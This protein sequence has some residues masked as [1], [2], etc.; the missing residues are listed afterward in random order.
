MPLR[1]WLLIL[2]PLV[3]VILLLDRP[4]STKSVHH[5]EWLDAG[6]AKLRGIR[7]GAG[8]TTLLLLHGFGESLL[9]WRSLVDPLAK[10]FRVVAV[11]VPPFGVSDKPSG[12]YS[13][14]SMTDRLN[15]LVDRWIPGP[16][17]VIGHSM[18]GELAVA[19]ALS[20]PTRVNALVLIAPA[21]IAIGMGG[22]LDTVRAGKAS[23]IAWWEASRSFLLPIHDAEWLQEP[24]GRS[25]YDPFTD[26]RFRPAVERLLK[27]FDFV[28]LRGQFGHLGQPTLLIWG[29]EDPVIPFRIGEE[30]ART[31]PCV[32]WVPLQNRLHRPHVEAPNEVLVAVLAFLRRPSCDAARPAL[33]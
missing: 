23:A 31:I 8:D 11:D 22:F 15:R 32:K 17:V 27:D 30:L 21:G 1:R 9:A 12:D 18:G 16:L 20:R 7:A 24:A 6:D 13:I 19:M 26:E 33:P 10:H 25:E 4:R 2:P 14:G 5:A 28:A 3:A 29:D